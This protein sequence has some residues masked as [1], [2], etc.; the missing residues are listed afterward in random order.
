VGIQTYDIGIAAELVAAGVNLI[1]CNTDIN[2]LLSGL[3]PGIKELREKVGERM[4][5]PTAK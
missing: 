4:S 5:S 2:A 3:E 1:S